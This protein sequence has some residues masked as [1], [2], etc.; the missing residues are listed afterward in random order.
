VVLI[1]GHQTSVILAIFF[2]EAHGGWA[3]STLNAHAVE[4][5]MSTVNLREV[6]IRI[7]DRQPQQAADLQSRLMESGIRFVAPDAGQARLAADARLR[8]PLN[9]GNCFAY[10]LAVTGAAPS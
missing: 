8:F 6:L 3:A 9:L 4:L 7:L 5:R 10:A 2:G 1:Y